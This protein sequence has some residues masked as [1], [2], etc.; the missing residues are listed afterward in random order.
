MSWW[1]KKINKT[2][3][4]SFFFIMIMIISSVASE[5]T[6]KHKANAGCKPCWPPGD[7]HL[8]GILGCGWRGGPAPGP[9]SRQPRR[10]PDPE[11]GSLG[12]SG[13][14]LGLP[15]SIP[16]GEAALHPEATSGMGLGPARA[17]RPGASPSC[18]RPVAGL[19]GGGGGPQRP[20]PHS[21]AQP[22][23]RLSLLPPARL[24]PDRI[25]LLC[26]E[27]GPTGRVYSAQGSG[28]GRRNQNKKQHCEKIVPRFLFVWDKNPGNGS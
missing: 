4:L 2:R 6:N 10:A 5:K 15:A 22:G 8:G 20:A 17:P 28:S 18:R 12:R 21:S 1:K 3:S 14:V 13:A 11:G 16:R 25:A 9:A 23:P 27:I 7:P 24:F 19:G 26:P